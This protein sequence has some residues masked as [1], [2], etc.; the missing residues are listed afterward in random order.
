MLL[1][2]TQRMVMKGRNVVLWVIGASTCCGLDL[3]IMDNVE[4]WET[5]RWGILFNWLKI[6]VNPS[7]TAS[8]R[9]EGN[10]MDPTICGVF[11]QQFTEWHFCAPWIRGWF[12]VNLREFGLIFLV[13]INS[14]CLEMYYRIYKIENQESKKII[15]LGEDSNPRP[16]NF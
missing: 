2:L 11:L 14:F 5:W 16:S 10:V 15:D 7:K 4:S 12:L 3:S 8:R 6:K 1:S 9:G 13:K